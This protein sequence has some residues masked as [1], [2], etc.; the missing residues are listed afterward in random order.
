MV[1]WGQDAWIYSQTAKASKLSNSSFRD[2]R[3]ACYSA[4]GVECWQDGISWASLLPT[5]FTN[6]V[7]S[8]VYCTADILELP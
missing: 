7:D 2:K 6:E 5:G 4:P 1:P 3:L 8:K